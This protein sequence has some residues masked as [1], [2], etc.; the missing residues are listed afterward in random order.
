MLDKSRGTQLSIMAIQ[1]VYLCPTCDAD[2]RA[3]QLQSNSPL[4]PD[5]SPVR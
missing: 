5:E 2:V 1:V 4:P 3:R